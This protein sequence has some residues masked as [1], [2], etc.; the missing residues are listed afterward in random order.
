M[1]LSSTYTELETAVLTLDPALHDCRLRIADI[2]REMD[3]AC[4]HGKITL[5]QW[6]GLLVRVA[7]IQSRCTLPAR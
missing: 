1:N 2:R 5:G 4:D 3:E 6:R 7:D